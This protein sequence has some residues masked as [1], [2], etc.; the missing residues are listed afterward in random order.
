MLIGTAIFG[1]GYS[2]ITI[3]VMPEILEAI[4][5][6]KDLSDN[7]DEDALYNNLAGYFVVCQ[8]VG[9]SSGPAL[10]SALNTRFDLEETQHMLAIFVGIFLASYMV[11]CDCRAFFSS[12]KP[13]IEKEKVSDAAQTLLNENEF[14]LN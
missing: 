6:R 14:K 9:E 5:D 1:M 12:P 8:A 3:P 13:Q 2:M 11:L 7:M 10:S 4:E